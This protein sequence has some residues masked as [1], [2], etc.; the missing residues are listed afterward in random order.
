MLSVQ[1]G[2]SQAVAR[3]FQSSQPDEVIDYVAR[4]LS[5]HRMNV[6]NP[7]NMAASLQCMRVA[8]V[9]IVDIRYGTDVS[10][11]AEDLGDQFLIHAGV[12]GVS[13][14]TSGGRAAQ[15]TPANIYIT[16]PGR[17]S[18]IHMPAQCRH[19][20]ARIAASTFET[21]LA[22]AMNVTMNRPLVFHGAREEDHNLP[23]AWRQLLHH[24]VSQCTLA[25]ALM[26]E[27]RIQRQ[28]SM[29]MLEM[30]LGGYAN[31]Y[32]DQI[33]RQG[34]DIAPRH[35]RK[36]REIIHESIEDSV[37]VA[38]IAAQVGVSTRSL[39]NGFRQFLGVTPAEYVRRHRLERLHT[40]LKDAPPDSSVTELMLECGIVNFGRFANYYRRQYGCRPSDTLRGL[41]L[42]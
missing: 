15:I 41:A 27:P 22:G 11:D 23:A 31:S 34:N 17:S 4:N 30:L 3:Q 1:N 20:A 33:A 21:H 40:V 10:I 14:V 7:S 13:K 2:S 16:S 26:S 8:G 38:D 24:I 9:Q 37:S 28:Y 5:P 25:P 18:R 36:A 12:S 19:I 32:S 6:T 35:V 39:Q 42:G 29:L